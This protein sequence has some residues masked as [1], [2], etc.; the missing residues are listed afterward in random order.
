MRNRILVAATTLAAGSVF[1]LAGP[2]A[3]QPQQNGLVNVNISDLDV[4]VP[5][6]VAANICDVSVAALTQLALDDAAPCDAAADPDAITPAGG[7]GSPSQEGLVNVNVSDITVQVPIGVAANVC[8]V[9]VAVLT[10]L[11]IDDSAPCTASADPTSMI[12][13]LG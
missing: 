2:A 11:A 7:G 8:D 10:G 6:G 12:T 4:Q 13:M 3:A 1:G 9:S 5:V